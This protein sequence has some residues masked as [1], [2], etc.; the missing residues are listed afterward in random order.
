MDIILL[1]KLFK[2]VHYKWL[3][4]FNLCISSKNWIN[5]TPHQFNPSKI[6]K[7]AKCPNFSVSQKSLLQTFGV[8]LIINIII[9]HTSSIINVI[10]LLASKFPQKK[11]K[12]MLYVWSMPQIGLSG[13]QAKCISVLTDYV[14]PPDKNLPQNN[15]LI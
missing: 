13:V 1:L 8:T 4:N 2:I 9:I 14:M 5:V 15:G 12:T 7:I 6:G 10:Q 3:I 11:T